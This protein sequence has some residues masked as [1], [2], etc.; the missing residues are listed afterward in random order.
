MLDGLHL[1]D[2][3]VE[4]VRIFQDAAEELGALG[5]VAGEL[6]KELEELCIVWNQTHASLILVLDSRLKLADSSGTVSKSGSAAAPGFILS[7]SVKV[8]AKGVL[9]EPESIPY[10]A[11]H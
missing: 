1:F 5:K 11:G 7:K 8:P 2:P 3:H 9:Q 4:V 6:G 10:V